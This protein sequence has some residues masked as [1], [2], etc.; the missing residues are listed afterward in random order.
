MV[1]EDLEK[2][3]A[4][5]IVTF[6]F[7]SI[8]LLLFLFVIAIYFDVTYVIQFYHT[9]NFTDALMAVFLAIVNVG[10]FLFL[11]FLIRWVRK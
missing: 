1:S 9:R 11:R 10:L 4:L 6:S 3:L 5:I 7:L 8:P 2:I